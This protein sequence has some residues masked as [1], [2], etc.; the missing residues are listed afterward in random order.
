MA[1]ITPQ[2]RNDQAKLAI[3]SARLAIQGNAFG[4]Q[5]HEAAVGRM[6]AAI[7]DV[8]DPLERLQFA[9]EAGR[10]SATNP[11]YGSGTPAYLG[12]QVQATN[13]WS[14]AIREMASH[15]TYFTSVKEQVG[16]TIR[17]T[18]VGSLIHDTAKQTDPDILLGNGLVVMAGRPP[19]GRGRAASRPGAHP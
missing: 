14:A 13:L 17:L 10:Q 8:I 6:I 12:H 2:M 5:R 4:T 11:M 3:E 7:P 1:I 15:P 9:R 16:R 19:V 18:H